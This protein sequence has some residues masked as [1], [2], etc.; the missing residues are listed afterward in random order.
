[1]I[2]TVVDLVGED[3]SEVSAILSNCGTPVE[4]N[5]SVSGRFKNGIIFSLS[6]AGDSI[7]CTSQISVFGDK[8][9]LQTG[10]W[11]EKLGIITERHRHN[12]EY[13][14]ITYPKSLGVWEQFLKV[15]A[16][17]MENPCPPEVGLRFAKLMDMIRNSAENGK[18]I[19]A[20]KMK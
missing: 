18:T 11:G 9:V 4:I 2:N 12:S 19:R 14:R 10:I 13:K 15:R 17:K 6:G 20:K 3:V 5:S 8:G 1:M 7:H 16:G